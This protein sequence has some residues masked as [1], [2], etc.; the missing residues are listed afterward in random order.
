[1]KRAWLQATEAVN[2][3]AI[4]SQLS[5]DRRRITGDLLKA[6]GDG[7]FHTL[8]ARSCQPL[9]AGLLVIC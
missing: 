9:S 7:F 2:N 3:S 4:S 8:S 1:M 5:A 6:D